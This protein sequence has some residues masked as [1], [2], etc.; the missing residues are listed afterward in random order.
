MAKTP[1]R[2]DL[3]TLDVNKPGWLHSN[4]KIVNYKED[5]AKAHKLL[6]DSPVVH[7]GTKYGPF[8][9]KY[10]DSMMKGWENPANIIISETANGEPLRIYYTGPELN[11]IQAFFEKEFGDKVSTIAA[12]KNGKTKVSRDETLNNGE[13]WGPVYWHVDTFSDSSYTILIYLTDVDEKSGPFEYAYPPEDY[14]YSKDQ[15]LENNIDPNRGT[16]HP[17]NS[18]IVTGP[19]YTALLFSSY[20]L[21]RGNYAFE[22]DRNALWITFNI[23]EKIANTSKD[24]VWDNNAK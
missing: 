6:E 10:I 1:I 18:V 20:L 5:A 14:I 24:K 7:L 4:Y 12:V 16:I 23:N 22:K 19:K 11:D 3:S 2:I 15:L 9:E 17:N 21:H 13:H 8:L